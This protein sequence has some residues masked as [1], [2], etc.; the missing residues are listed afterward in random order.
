MGRSWKEMDVTK[1]ILFM[2]CLIFVYFCIFLLAV[3]LAVACAS[4][5]PFF[6]WQVHEVSAGAVTGC[7][8]MEQHQF[9][10]PNRVGRCEISRALT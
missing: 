2:V 5:Y 6:L 3:D 8:A 10:P 1:L 7:F 4:L 9:S